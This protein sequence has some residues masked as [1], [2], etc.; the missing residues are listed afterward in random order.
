MALRH[1][2]AERGGSREATAGTG[3]SWLRPSL[4]GAD[5][6]PSHA[7]GRICRV[8]CLNQHWFLSLDEARAVAEARREDYDRDR[9]H[10]ALGNRT[11]SEFA[12]LIDVATTGRRSVTRP[13]KPGRLTRWLSSCSSA[14][15]WLRTCHCP[16]NP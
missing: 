7:Q 1:A 12:R 11:P 8:E 10:G 2:S 9:P 14:E 3:P 13:Q 4:G 16:G 15:P 5:E 6:F